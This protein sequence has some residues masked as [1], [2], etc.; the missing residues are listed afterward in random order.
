MTGQPIASRRAPHFIIRKVANPAD[1][2]EFLGPATFRWLIPP[3]TEVT[4]DVFAE[5]YKPWV[6]TETPGTLTPTPFRVESGE[7]KILDIRLERQAPQKNHP[8]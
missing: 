7:D 3:A 6:Y 1:S 8:E 5:D 2:I 4:L